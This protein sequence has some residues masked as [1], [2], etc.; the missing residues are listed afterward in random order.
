MISFGIFPYIKYEMCTA[1]R[2]W[3]DCLLRSSGAPVIM[4]EEAGSHSQNIECGRMESDARIDEL[5]D[6]GRLFNTSWPG[7]ISMTL[8]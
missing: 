3:L 8:D 6:L 7:A 5:H 4:E 2:F 1:V